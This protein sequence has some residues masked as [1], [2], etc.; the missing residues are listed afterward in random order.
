MLAN[1]L[2]RSMP[3]LVL[4]AVV[5]SL[6]VPSVH[7]Q[8]SSGDLEGSWHVFSRWDSPI[9]HDAGYDQI[10]GFTVGPGGVIPN[11]GG[12]VTSSDLDPDQVAGGSLSIDSGGRFGGTVEFLG[13]PNVVIDGFQ[14]GAGSLAAPATTPPSDLFAGTF[15]D[16]EGAVNLA[17]G[18]RQLPSGFEIGDITGGVT[19]H[20]FS[21]WDQPDFGGN[22]P[23]WDRGTFRFRPTT[24]NRADIDDSAGV[25]SDGMSFNLDDLEVAVQVDGRVTPLPIPGE[26]RL[27]RDKNI[28]I[29]VAIDPDGYRNLA[30][31][32]RSPG[33]S[34]QS[35]LEGP[36]TWFRFVDDA[37][38][39]APGWARGVIEVDVDGNITS[40]T[41]ERSDGSSDWV[42]GGSLLVGMASGSIDGTILYA[43]S[44]PDPIEAGRLSI[45]DNLWVAVGS[46]GSERRLTVAM[47][48]PEPAIAVGI[49][50]GW[51]ALV[52]SQARLPLR[53][54]AT[55][56]AGPRRRATRPARP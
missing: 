56:P 55:G 54:G 52:G 12:S 7:A 36:W 51:L 47:P 40:G 49:G 43:N 19:W 18:V 3:R 48:V 38:A 8:F 53:P 41:I 24:G 4:V 33:L 20:F 15:T 2:I 32:L 22:D 14:V 11:G 42:T 13:G 6:C 29:G 9:S 50:L 21:H 44:A 5:S 26:F 23:G 28:I 35:D 34:P 30:V 16:S 46:V 1:L 25:D 10:L 37:L 45:G 27:T 39:N 17:L 31:M